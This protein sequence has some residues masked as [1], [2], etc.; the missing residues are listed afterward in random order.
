MS[1]KCENKSE[2]KSEN[3]GGLFNRQTCKLFLEPFSLAE[4]EEYL[5]SKGIRWSRYDITECYM[6]MGGIPYYLSLLDKNMS[7]LQKYSHFVK[8][9]EAKKK[10]T[11]MRWR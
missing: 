3:K 7:Y 9:P 6:I 2:N 10:F 11:L 1:K 5:V 8:F 4:T